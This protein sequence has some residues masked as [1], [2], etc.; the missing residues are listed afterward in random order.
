MA[1]E[2]LIKSSYGSEDCLFA[3]HPSD[4]KSALKSLV[5]AQEE[6]VGFEEFLEKHRVYLRSK[7]CSEEHISEQIKRVKKVTNYFDAD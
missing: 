7:N 3:M 6:E 1:L 5:V 2:N 4:I